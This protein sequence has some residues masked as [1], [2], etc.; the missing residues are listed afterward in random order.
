MINIKEEHTNIV[1]ANDSSNKI[2]LVPFNQ[3]SDQSV[4]NL[5]FIQTKQVE[6]PEIVY[7]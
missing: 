5:C 4:N 3:I 6:I 7:T 2:E 1:A